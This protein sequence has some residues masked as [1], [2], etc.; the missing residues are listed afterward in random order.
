MHPRIALLALLLACAASAH[1]ADP[2]SECVQELA[3]DAGVAPLAGK[4]LLSSSTGASFDMLIDASKPNEGERAA[5]AAWG[6][7]RAACWD[8]ASAHLRA[9]TLPAQFEVFESFNAG[10]L[11]LIADLHAGALTFGEFNKQRGA[12]AEKANALIAE[13]LKRQPSQGDLDRAHAEC[14]YEVRRTMAGATPIPY[15]A[16]GTGAMQRAFEGIGSAQLAAG[17]REGLYLA[18]MNS[19]GWSQRAD[20]V[21]QSAR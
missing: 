16:P 21:W 4:V 9:N 7:G 12:M 2:L 15:Q 8:R 17:Q 11:R 3:R 20:G 1:A 13:A 18:C 10:V 19:R 14:V 5:L 6:R